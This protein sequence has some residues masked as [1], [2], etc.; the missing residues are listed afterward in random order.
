M[1]D[2]QGSQFSGH[3]ADRLLPTLRDERD[4][5][6][7]STSQTAPDP[8]DL[9]SDNYAHG[10]DTL[11]HD[12]LGHDEGRSGRSGRRT[13]ALHFLEMLVVMFV[14]MGAFSGLA[15]L[16]FRLAGSRPDQPDG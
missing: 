15:E 6:T 1:S 13:F 3:D 16:A 2:G 9:A 12:T 10:H 8:Q 7:M 4:P 11:G 14:G 5:R